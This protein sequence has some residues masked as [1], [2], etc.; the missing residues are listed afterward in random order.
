MGLPGK[1]GDGGE[2][3]EVM[4]RSLV[5]HQG[6]NSLSCACYPPNRH[7][8][9]GA[10]NAALHASTFKKLTHQLVLSIPT[11]LRDAKF[12]KRGSES[13][14]DYGEFPGEARLDVDT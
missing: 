7:F 2:E 14:M 5:L 9:L 10:R 4:I 3:P 12:G 6:H 13:I 11:I 8:N 1:R